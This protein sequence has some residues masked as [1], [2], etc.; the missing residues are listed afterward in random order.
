[1]K[2]R[3]TSLIMLALAACCMAAQPP[4]L[5]LRIDREG[6]GSA[7]LGDVEAVLGSAADQLLP[8]FPGIE[9][10]PVRVSPRGGPIVLHRRGEDGSIIM[11][12][13]TGD[14][15]WSQ[16]AFQF[17][18]ELCHILCRYDTDPTGN[19]WFEETICELASLYTLRSMGQA[20][21]TRPPYPNWKG[22]AR[23]LTAYAQKRIDDSPLPD[24]LTL[25]QW[26]R[27]NA[28]ALGANATDRGKNT[29]IAAALLPLFE[30]EP[31]HWAAVWHLNDAT[32]TSPQSFEAYLADWHAH[33]PAEHRAFVRAIAG[34]FGIRLKAP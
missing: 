17:A 7:V 21:Q 5:E 9:L 8:H 27:R 2:V 10:P 26:Y 6:W 32:P 34:E 4:R 30:R 25:A 3:C 23:H 18:H 33:V 24:G 11:R 12:L 20:W 15:F 1:M 19:K 13:N 31:R 29:I 28:E 14:T 22:Y 16:Y